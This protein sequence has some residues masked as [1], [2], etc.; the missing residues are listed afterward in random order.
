LEIQSK[1]KADDEAIFK[2]AQ[3]LKERKKTELIAAL[4]EQSKIHHQRKIEEKKYMDEQVL[5]NSLQF[6][7]CCTF[8]LFVTFFS[9]H[10]FQKVHS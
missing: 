9:G 4:E 7:I 5:L 1:R 6:E 2:K 8:Y 10:S 3:E